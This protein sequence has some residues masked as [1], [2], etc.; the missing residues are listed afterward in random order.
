MPPQGLVWQIRSNFTR[1]APGLVRFRQ[2]PTAAAAMQSQHPGAHKFAPPTQRPLHSTL[3][4]AQA[5]FD[6]ATCGSGRLGGQ[7]IQLALQPS[8]LFDELIDHRV[9]RFECNATR[10]PS[11]AAGTGRAWTPDCLRR[12]AIVKIAS[13]RLRACAARPLEAG[14]Q[15]LLRCLRLPLVPPQ[16]MAGCQPSEMKHGCSYEVGTP[17]W[18]PRAPNAA[19]HRPLTF[20]RLT[21]T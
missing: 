12:N 18:R 21:A 11:D 9:Q 2:L 19:Q 14:T 10:G 16:W 4:R 15:C 1:P 3:N 17:A 7:P 6:V 5:T 8:V 13:C 20:W